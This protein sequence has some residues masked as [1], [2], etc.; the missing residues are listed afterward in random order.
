MYCEVIIPLA[1]PRPYTYSV[2]K[3]LESEVSFGKRVEVNFGKNKL[4]AGLI[5]GILSDHDAPHQLKPIL[6]VI[7]ST[8]IINPSHL[9]LWSWIASYYLCTLGEVMNAAIPSGLKLNSETYVVRN[10]EI[11]YDDFELSDDEFLICEALQIQHEINLADI[12]KILNKKSV[13]SIL[14]KMLDKNFILFREELK[15]KYK[16]KKIKCIRFSFDLAKNTKALNEALESCSKSKVQTSAILFLIQLLKAQKYVTRSELSIHPEISDHAIRTLVKKEILTEYFISDKHRLSEEELI[17]TKNKLSNVQ[18]KS[19][20]DIHSFFTENKPVL[21]QGVTGSGKTHIYIELIKHFLK[22]NKQVLYLLPEIAISTQLISRLKKYF[23]DDTVIY[24]SRL[25]QRERVESWLACAKGNKLI[26][27]VRSSIFLPFQNLGLIIVDESHDNSLKQHDPAPRY[28]A[29]DVALY[30]Q[31]TTADCKIIMGTATPDIE[32]YHNARNNKYGY[33][34]LAE[35]HNGVPVPVP[36]IIDLAEARKN[37]A[38]FGTYSKRLLDEIDLSLRNKKQTILFQNRR[39]FAPV[40]SCEYCGWSAICKSCDVSL[41]YHKYRNLL[42]CHYCGR[43]YKFKKACPQCDKGDLKLSGL[44]TEKIE[45]ELSKFFPEARI[46]RMDLDTVRKKN[47]HA[48][49]ISQFENRKIDILIGTQMVTKGL[50]F[51]NVSLVGIINADQQLHFPDFRSTEKSFQIF[52]QVSGRAGRTEQG[53]AMI[54]TFNPKHPVFGFVRRN[55]LDLLYQY[56]LESRKEFRY[57][58]YVR[59]IEIT[60]KHKQKELVMK[61]ASIFCDLL[62]QQITSG[63]NGPIEPSISRVK[64]MYIRKVLIKFAPNNQTRKLVKRHLKSCVKELHQLKGF[65]NVRINI[66]VDPV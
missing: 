57:P 47:S 16:P 18:E 43:T 46:K 10:E 49:L 20:E 8:S 34:H 58:P 65:T 15:K 11:N 55:D 32:S 48:R 56:E 13:S 1:I 22:Q 36:E 3:A 7:D 42:S 51:E 12:Q 41:T 27:G 52:T 61:A 24:H 35:R 30:L 53:K 17:L 25:N 60:I 5:V 19:L 39:G 44:G 2:P 54:Q 50:D 63:V 26:I 33:V 37:Q 4:Y 28:N 21:F 62:I 59:L 9:K 29:R 40:L 31:S 23:G 6:S 66:D 45:E 38:L 64:S 14:N